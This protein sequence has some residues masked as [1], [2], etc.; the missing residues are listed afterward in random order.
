MKVW[1]QNLVFTN[2]RQDN[3]TKNNTLWCFNNLCT[4]TFKKSN[5]SFTGPNPFTPDEQREISQAR[6]NDTLSRNRLLE[7]KNNGLSISD[8]IHCIKYDE[9]AVERFKTLT[10]TDSELDANDKDAIIAC[11]IDD[12][13]IIRFKEIKKSPLELYEAAWATKFNLSNDNIKIYLSK[14]AN[15][16]RYMDDNSRIQEWDAPVNELMYLIKEDFNDEQLLRFAKFRNK[17]IDLKDKTVRRTGQEELL[18]PKFLANAIKRGETDEVI[19][20]SIRLIEL[21]NCELTNDVKASIFC[22]SDEHYNNFLKRLG[23]EKNISF[24]LSISRLTDEQYKKYQNKVANGENKDFALRFSELQ[25]T[26]NQYNK[27]R[28]LVANGEEPPRAIALVQLTDE[29]IGEYKMLIANGVHE[30]Q[31]LNIVK[32]DKK[33][34]K[35]YHNLIS[36]GINGFTALSIVELQ[37]EQYEKYLKF[38]ANNKLE[39]IAIDLAMLTDEQYENF[40]TFV[41]TEK[42]SYDALR[43]AQL[44]FTN[45]EYKR[46]QEL[47]TNAFSKEIARDIA[48]LTVEECE[49]YKKL[50][51]NGKDQSAAL[52]SVILTDSEQVKYQKFLKNG[53]RKDMAVNLARLT[54]IEYNNYQKRSANDLGPYERL[55]LAKLSDKQYKKYLNFCLEGENEYTALT[56]AK[57]TDEQISRYQNLISTEQDEGWG[58][59]LAKLTNEQY[60][61]YQK[62][63]TNGEDKYTA[64]ILA[65]LTT[66]QYEKYQM[67][68]NE[69]VDNDLAI[70]TALLTNEQFERYQNLITNGEDRYWALNLA[71]LSI[72]QFEKYKK[73][74]IKLSHY[75]ALA[76]AKNTNLTSVTQE[77]LEKLPKD[78]WYTTTMGCEKEDSETFREAMTFLLSLQPEDYNALETINP[79]TLKNAI[80]G[81]YNTNDY[82]FNNGIFK[83]FGENGFEAKMRQKVINNKTCLLIKDENSENQYVACNGATAKVKPL[84]ERDSKQFETWGNLLARKQGAILAEAAESFVFNVFDESGNCIIGQEAPI[85]NINETSDADIESIYAT[86]LLGLQ[87]NEQLTTQNILKIMP[88][89]CMLSINPYINEGN[90]LYSIV[91][92]WISKD[93]HR[94]QL[95]V[96]SQDLKHSTDEKW[97]CRLGKKYQ[98]SDG[99]LDR[100]LRL[101]PSSYDFD[102]TFSGEESRDAHIKI[103]TPLEEN[104]LLNNVNF[105][106]IMRKLS[107]SIAEKNILKNIADALGLSFNK[108]S[109]LMGHEI[110][111]HCVRNL[112]SLVIYKKE[113]SKIGNKLGMLVH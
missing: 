60:E 111:K 53:E 78:F 13:Q 107:S 51:A 92:E 83:L 46:Y 102:G 30:L 35:K 97:I 100:Y 55:K 31:A 77:I 84:E 110:I 6:M 72:E 113:V 52:T 29:Q 38:S 14:K 109:T 18:S 12:S 45:E 17:R 10:D 103:P 40:Q 11:D 48:K 58:L 28:Q 76:L 75:Q 19:F 95:E 2:I 50:V 5:I 74:P 90:I 41:T 104:D 32:L 42:D 105:Q 15:G 7:L 82:T 26:D 68:I 59:S 61:E 89:D 34:Y 98:E 108:N 73:I 57:F 43:L 86:L 93:N 87:Q 27:Y 79:K 106:I 8:A 65:S 37:D 21:G 62:I 69:G 56:L 80:Q 63:I 39:S 33:Q 4:D 1:G 36:N 99:S 25:L 66:E 24:L 20:R 67:L 94:W 88:K 22:L 64:K 47:V 49:R 70:D 85:S 96:H 3:N 71:Y 112:R 16:V 81:I 91:A 23:D 9:F 54:D 44:E 101:Y